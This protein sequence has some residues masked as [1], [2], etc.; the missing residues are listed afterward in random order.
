MHQLDPCSP[1]I[2]NHDA[3]TAARLVDVVDGRSSRHCGERVEISGAGSEECKA[4]ETGCI[5]YFA[6]M[7]VMAA[8][9]AAHVESAV[10]ARASLDPEVAEVRLHAVEIGHAKAHPY[11]VSDLHDWFR[12]SLCLLWSGAQR[13]AGSRLC[14]RRAGPAAATG[15][16]QTLQKGRD[17]RIFESENAQHEVDQI[18]FN[19]AA[20][21]WMLGRIE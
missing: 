20:I 6:D 17:P 16:P 11:D 21:V 8:A 7:Q 19:R 2:V 10:G 14:R 3:A 15:G 5:A 12:H 9:G 1:R 4:N 13:C 18:R